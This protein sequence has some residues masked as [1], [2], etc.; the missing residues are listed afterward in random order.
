VSG[1]TVLAVDDREDSLRF[2]REY[3]LEPN[4][5]IML[6]ARNGLDALQLALGQK[7]DL[8]ISDLVMPK[9]GGLELLESLRERGV[10]TPAILMTFHGSEGTAVRAFRLGARDYIIK[11]F[12]IDEMLHAIDRALSESRLRQER[13]QL[14][15][16]VLRVNR[17]LE[18]RVQELR[19][20]YGIGRSVTSLQQLEQVLNRIVEAATYLTGAEEGS[21]MLID[22]ASGELY[23]RAARG[24]GEKNAKTFRMKIQDSI[25]GQVVRTGRPVMIGGINQDDSFKVTTGYFVKAMLNVPLKVADRVI[26]VLAVNNKTNVR[27]FSERHLNLL[28]A[29][30]DYASI[31]IE[32]V[33]LYKRLTTQAD[34]TEQ[35]NRQLAQAVKEKTSELQQV[36]EQLIKSEKLAAMGYMAAGLAKEINTPIQTILAKLQHFSEQVEPA[37]PNLPLAASLEHEVLHCQQL[38]H[39]LLDFS[40]QRQQPAQALNLNEAIE[41]AWSKYNQ[42]Y[43]L[44]NQIKFIRGFDPQLPNVSVD[45]QQMGQAL[46]FLIKN[47]C[48]M[49]PQ[50][51]ILRIISR[52][53]GPEVQVIVSDT[54]IGI[55]A[56]EMRHIFDPFYEANGHAYGLGL[57]IAHAVVSRHSGKI[58]VESQAGQGTTFTIRLPRMV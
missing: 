26:G 41:A 37:S 53:V 46:F 14:T 35:E 5:Y 52:L 16:T 49:M 7:V 38:V 10:D 24:M 4:G 9:M 18:N 27:A 6:Q 44:H 31:A 2:L 11:P 43:P 48:E 57:S 50:G 34:Q 40:G 42:E 29:L 12:A 28:T 33:R 8:I 56:E 19:F 3:V 1:E 22:Q 39:S 51:G 45:P 25:A 13:D 54:G 21:I 36:N 23:L 15:Q 20:L 32:N 55:S 58:E 17:Q 30:S 47:A